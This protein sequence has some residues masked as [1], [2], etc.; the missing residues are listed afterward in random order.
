MYKR[1][2]KSL[3]R[4][5]NHSIFGKIYT[6]IAMLGCTLLAS[7]NCTASSDAHAASA[8]WPTG[9]VVEFRAR[10]RPFI[11][12]S[13]LL[14][15]PENRQNVTRSPTFL[16]YYPKKTALGDVATLFGVKGKMGASRYDR[17]FRPNVRFRVSI[18]APQYRRL[19]I[20]ANRFKRHRP[21]FHLLANNCNSF[22]QRMALSLGLR[23]PGNIVQPPVR[24]ISALKRLNRQHTRTNKT[25]ARPNQ[26]T[27]QRD[28]P[29]LAH[30]WLR[31][32]R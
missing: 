13:Y 12:H 17:H 26:S 9:Y 27:R 6:L 20:A 25:H 3:G 23:A 10:N 24:Y 31:K 29:G 32:K 18:T 22:A 7:A 28:F 15:W 30:Q 4:I 19:I 1:R 8:K 14:V 11:G 5:G 21:T 2:C 16:G